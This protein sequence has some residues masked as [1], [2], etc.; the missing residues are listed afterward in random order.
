MEKKTE[1]IFLDENL[2]NLENKD[3]LEEKHALLDE[4]L[5]KTIVDLSVPEELRIKALNAYYTKEG[6]NTVETVNKLSTLYQIGGTKL[7]RKYLYSICKDS[8]LS[9]LLKSIIAK[10]LCVFN[11]K[12]EIGYEALA[13]IYPELQDSVGTPYKIELLILMMNSEKIKEQTQGYFSSIINN[14]KLDCSYRY[15]IILGLDIEKHAY[16]IKNGC[17][18]FIRNQENPIS[19]CIL[20]IQ[21]ILV[22]KLADEHTEELYDC[23]YSIGTNSEV[24]YNTRADAT[25][26]LLQL[27][28]DERKAHARELIMELGTD[29]KAGS[30]YSNQQN[31]HVKEIE[32]SVKQ[33]LQFLQNFDIMKIKGKTIT[34][35]YVEEEIIELLE[36]YKDFDSAKIKLALNRIAND[37]ALYSNYSCTLSHILLQV[38]SYINKN[39]HET[40]MKKRLLEELVEMAGTC[41]SGYCTRLLNSISGFGDFNMVISWRDQII[42]NLT[43]RLNAKLKQLEDEKERDEILSEMSTEGPYEDRMHFLGFFRKVMLGIREEMF[44]EFKDHISDTDF[45]LYF[46]QAISMYET[47]QFN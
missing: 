17:L 38:W 11:E 47:G 5:S 34:F 37:R 13:F 44:E 23:L 30:L 36:L 24:E 40:E 33:A 2:D 42:S 31:V 29:G 20:A 16:F 46:R 41:S 18:A 45:D 12:D 39:T 8:I 4:N 1:I 19:Y 21:Y 27:G 15:K 6:E 7:M 3:N 32:D 25:D 22:K 9:P 43:G 26:V 14:Q 28:S 10:N 35:E